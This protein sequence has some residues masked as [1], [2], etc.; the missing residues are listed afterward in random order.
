MTGV[1]ARDGMA[2]KGLYTHHTATG[3]EFLSQT[4]Q[5]ALGLHFA[6]N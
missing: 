4:Q 3:F 5:E 1:D 6:Q 2:G